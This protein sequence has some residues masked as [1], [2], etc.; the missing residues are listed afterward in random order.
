MI[1]VKTSQNA[2]KEA[3]LSKM[4]YATHRDYG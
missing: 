4:R 1:G 2:K 3:Y